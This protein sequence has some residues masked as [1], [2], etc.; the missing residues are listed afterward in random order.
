MLAGKI[1]SEVGR[2]LRGLHKDDP[3]YD[4][5]GHQEDGKGCLAHYSSQGLS[6]K[7]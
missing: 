2:L 1:I 4:I 3:I 6:L 5:G 7:E